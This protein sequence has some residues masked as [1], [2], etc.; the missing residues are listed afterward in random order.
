DRNKP[1]GMT[2]SP[3]YFMSRFLPITLRIARELRERRHKLVAKK[4]CSIACTHSNANRLL[5]W[6]NTSGPRELIVAGGLVI[7]LWRA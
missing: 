4:R 6:G 1:A 2:T 7:A 3:A 5:R